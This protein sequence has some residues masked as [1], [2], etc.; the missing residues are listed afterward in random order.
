MSN[1]HL[2]NDSSPSQSNEWEAAALSFV[3]STSSKQ[4]SGKSAKKKRGNRRTL[5]VILSSAGTILLACI[6]LVIM[7][8]D[9]FQ[10][11][12]NSGDDDTTQSTDSIVENTTPSITLLDKTGNAE[13]GVKASRLSRIDITN[14]DDTF[15]IR[16]DSEAKGYVINGY[17]DIDLSSS[18]LTTLRNYTE[19]IQATDLVEN[20][21]NLAAFGLDEPQATATITYEDQ[22]T[23][24]IR[25]GSETPSKSGYYG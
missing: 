4:P 13:T 18:L 25:V 9:G 20:V 2:N 14:T 12:Q 7:L 1:E 16:Y 6:V 3:E 5:S 8:T 21:T 10:A 19:K 11:K 15:T 22:S 24:T 23:A 17:E